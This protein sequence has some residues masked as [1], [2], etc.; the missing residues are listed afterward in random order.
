MSIAT[1]PELLIFLLLSGLSLLLSCVTLWH[2]IPIWRRFD[3]KHHDAAQLQLEKRSYFASVVMQFHILLSILLLPY[4]IFLLDRL[5]L[6]IPGAMCA[7]GVVGANDYGNAVL[8]GFLLE[9][10][11][12]ILWLLLHWLDQRS[13]AQPYLKTK[14]ALIL[15]FF[16]IV[17]TTLVLSLLYFFSLDTQEVVQCCSLLY[18][19]GRADGA[20]QLQLPEWAMAAGFGFLWLA[21]L[22]LLTLQSRFSAIILPLFFAF[23]YLAITHLFSPYIYE[24]PTHHC[25]Y[26][27]FQA[28]YHYVG[29]PLALLLIGGSALGIATSLI[30]W[31]FPHERP[32]LR[33]ITRIALWA[34]A[35]FGIMAFWFPVSYY[36]RNGVWL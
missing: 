25:P 10:T 6:Y 31:R 4:L 15:P 8:I 24:L 16:G 20:N 30:A 34:I 12:G 36:L 22:V 29:Y 1:I 18:G 27:L 11:L 17:L 26:C 5:S 2:A 3:P 33:P 19:E 9:I 35:F 28:E 7:A 23:S 32:A 14:F 13:P 21:A